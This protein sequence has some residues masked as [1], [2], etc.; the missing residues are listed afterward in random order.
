MIAAIGTSNFFGALFEFFKGESF[1]SETAKNINN[2]VSTGA[3]TIT[4]LIDEKSEKQQEKHKNDDEN[5]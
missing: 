2:L 1:E 4:I 5:L 3:K